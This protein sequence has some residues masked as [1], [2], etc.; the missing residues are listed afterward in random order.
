ML[1][2]GGPSNRQ[3]REEWQQ[4]FVRISVRIRHDSY[5]VV[6]GHGLSQKEIILK[7]ETLWR[8]DP[9]DLSISTSA[10]P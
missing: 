7:N 10:R 2:H 1:V 5:I 3:R 4:T 6:S 9:L 8:I